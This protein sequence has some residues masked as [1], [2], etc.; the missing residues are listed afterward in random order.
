VREKDAKIEYG[1]VWFGRHIGPSFEV[2]RTAVL[3]PKGM[4]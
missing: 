1:I 2:I 4:T 3:E